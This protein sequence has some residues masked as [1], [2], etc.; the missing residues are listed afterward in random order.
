MERERLGDFGIEN[1]Q[2]ED[3]RTGAA[4]GLK[5][6]VKCVGFQDSG[7]EVYQRDLVIATSVIVRALRA[8]SIFLSGVIVQIVWKDRRRPGHLAIRR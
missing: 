8:H 2:E 3:S 4:R 7:A 5:G 6:N 1:M